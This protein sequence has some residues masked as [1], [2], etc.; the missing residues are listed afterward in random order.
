MFN[1]L[2]LLL[3]VYNNK[4]HVSLHGLNYTH[5]NFPRFLVL[6]LDVLTATVLAILSKRCDKLNYRTRRVMRVIVAI[7]V[8]S[9]LGKHGSNVQET[10][11]CIYNNF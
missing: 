11:L 3:N 1:D 4:S 7:A 8:Q 10:I 9:V 5:N 2:F 6:T